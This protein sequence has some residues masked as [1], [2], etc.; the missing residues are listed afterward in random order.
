MLKVFRI[1]GDF[2]IKISISSIIFIENLS[3]N[4]IEYS[5]GKYFILS[6][7]ASIVIPESVEFQKTKSDKYYDMTN[8]QGGYIFILKESLIIGCF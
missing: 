1:L 3:I 2:N 8:E 4:N 7:N 6:K 5:E